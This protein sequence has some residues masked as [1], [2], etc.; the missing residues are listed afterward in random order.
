[1][2]ILLLFFRQKA[3][4]TTKKKQLIDNRNVAGGMIQVANPRKH[5]QY[6]LTIFNYMKY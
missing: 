1:M 6:Y 5:F 2:L 4:K 3:K